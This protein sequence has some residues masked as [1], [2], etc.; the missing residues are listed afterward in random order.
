MNYVS[1]LKED[2]NKLNENKIILIDDGI[3][4]KKDKVELYK[5]H[6]QKILEFVNKITQD[7]KNNL[8]RG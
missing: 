2:Y 8:R 5:K 6:K 4:L 7:K 1:N 3:H